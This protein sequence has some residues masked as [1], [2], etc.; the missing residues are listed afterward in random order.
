VTPH[1]TLPLPC[2]EALDAVEEGRVVGGHRQTNAPSR[3]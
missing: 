3:S 2:R 1:M